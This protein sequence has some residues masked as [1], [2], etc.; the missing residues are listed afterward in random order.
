MTCWYHVCMIWWYSGIK[1][2]K[3]MDECGSDDLE[4]LYEGEGCDGIVI[5][6]EW[7]IDTYVL[8][9]M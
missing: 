2:L 3:I 1:I 9:L 6:M 5:D 8:Y 7:Y 4:W